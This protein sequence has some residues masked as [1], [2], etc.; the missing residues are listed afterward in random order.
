MKTKIKVKVLTNGCMPEITEKGDWIDLKSACSIKIPSAQIKETTDKNN[1]SYL[2]LDME[3]LYIPLGVAIE[4]PKGYEAIIDSRSSGPRKLGLFIPSGQGVVDNSYNGNEDEW[5]YVCS[6]MRPTSIIK[7]HRIC[8]FRIQ[9]SQKAT[10]WQKIKW[11]FSSGIE[12]E[13]VEE[14]SN[15]NRGGLGSSGVV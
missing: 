14:L 7:G 11:L 2:K 3:T 10:M 13:E 12:L 8:Q 15:S 5:H 4:L 6:A 1:K 9:L